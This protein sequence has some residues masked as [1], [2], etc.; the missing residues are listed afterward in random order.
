M[1]NEWQIGLLADFELR[2]TFVRIIFFSSS[3]V[4][5][6]NITDTV[7]C[8]HITCHSKWESRPVTYFLPLVWESPLPGHFKPFGGSIDNSTVLV[9]VL[10]PCFHFAHANGAERNLARTG[11]FCCSVID[12]LLVLLLHQCL[13]C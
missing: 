3:M 7:V 8:K 4:L 9:V 2:D 12:L 1:R 10:R 6:T 13:K 5:F 11:L